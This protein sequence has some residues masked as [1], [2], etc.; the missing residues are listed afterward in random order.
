MLT[1]LLNPHP[2]VFW[3]AVGGP[4]VA[5]AHGTSPGAVAAF[6]VGFFGCIVGAKAVMALAIGRFRHLLSGAGYRWTMRALAAGMLL[7]AL[8]FAEEGLSTVLQMG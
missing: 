3:L 5:E 7:L 2:Y 1:N 8:R 4:L 6:L